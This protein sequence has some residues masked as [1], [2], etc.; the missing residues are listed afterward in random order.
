MTVHQD[1]IDINRNLKILCESQNTTEFDMTNFI[2]KHG[3]QMHSS[4]ESKKFAE[5]MV[6]ERLI[7]VFGDFCALEKFGF[8]VCKN[9]GWLKHLSD[10]EKQETELELKSKEKDK[11][12]LEVKLLQKN[13]LQYKET[14]REQ[15]D[16]IRNLSEDLKLIS[17]VQKYWW[18]IGACIGIG[19]SLG[20]ILDILRCT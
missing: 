20:D 16:R 18:L 13:E 5:L 11:L 19:W 6:R 3:R 9:G 4:N 7:R 8:E 1:D 17:L 12:D 2:N 15:N 10:K 14:I